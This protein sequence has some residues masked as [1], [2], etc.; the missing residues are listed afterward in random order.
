MRPKYITKDQLSRWSK[1]IDLSL[2]ESVN[3]PIVR[4]VCYAG[5]WLTGVLRDLHC[6]EQLI[7]RI[8]FTA[9]KVSFGRDPWEIHQYYIDGYKN[10]KLDF[11][12]DKINLN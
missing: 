11:V 12:I 7:E 4:E 10:N 1:E 5:L 9:G 8:Q 3:I 6:P 2:P